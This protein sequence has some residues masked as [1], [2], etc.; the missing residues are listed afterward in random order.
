MRTKKIW[1]LFIVLLSFLIT[2]NS[3]GIKAYAQDADPGGATGFTYQ[4]KFPEN[5]LEEN[6]GYYSLK[7][8]PSD[9]QMLNI[10]LIN[11]GKKKVTIDVGI[12]GA[13]TN[14]NGVLEYGN[15]SIENDASLKFDFADIVTGPKSVDLEPGETKDLELEIQMPETGFDGSI[16]GGI[17]LMRKNNDD[18]PEKG[19]SKIINEYA[20]VIAV[21]L[22]ET[23]QVLSPELEL[24]EVKA[25]QD[26][27]RNTIFINFSNIVATYLDD[28][29]V[30]VQI[31][32]KGKETV[33]YE[34][35]QTAM[36]MAPNSFIKFPVSMNG[37]K[38]KAGKYEAK[39]LVS[40]SE[41]KKWSW[42]KEFEITQKDADKFNERDV[43]LVQEKGLDWQLIGLVAAGVIGII[44]VIFSLLIFNRK[45]KEKRRKL[46]RTGKKGKPQKMSDTAKKKSR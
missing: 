7:M 19:G 6:I 4:L 20:Y 22:Q 26:N 36:R 21:L 14:Q 42:T 46:N 15:S 23:D 8:K 12:N 35:K 24:N 28:M 11:P 16:A 30:E 27:A 25:D 31:N 39:I 17:Q 1:A 13:K 38:M 18:A 44:I 10:A 37:E 45:R 29:T 34:R 41:D 5:Q 9:H 32:E 33:L 40:G 2:G 3:M 43:G